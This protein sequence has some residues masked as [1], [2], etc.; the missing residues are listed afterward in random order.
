M[1][2]RF[3]CKQHIYLTNRKQCIHFTSCFRHSSIA[4]VFPH[5]PTFGVPTVTI[6][7]NK[8]IFFVT[9]YTLWESVLIFLPSYCYVYIQ[10]KDL[11]RFGVILTCSVSSQNT[12]K[13]PV[14]G[15][16]L[17]NHIFDKIMNKKHTRLLSLTLY[18]FT[19]AFTTILK[20]FQVST[21]IKGT[22]SYVINSL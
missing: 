4:I 17:K 15:Y 13:S 5:P 12:Q 7:Y 21:N 19:S 22:Q 6:F 3:L 9:R 18:Q 16:L 1:F 14:N 8:V 10:N 11:R 20:Q 2:E